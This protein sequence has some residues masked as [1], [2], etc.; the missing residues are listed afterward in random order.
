H[1]QRL[2][3][4]PI[5]VVDQFP[6]RLKA[7]RGRDGLDELD[8]LPGVAELVVDRM[9]QRMNGCRLPPASDNQAAAAVSD[10]IFGDRLRPTLMFGRGL[11]AVDID[12]ADFYGDG[13]SQLLNLAA[14]YRKPMVRLCARATDGGFSDIEPIHCRRGSRL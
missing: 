2:N 10:Q 8:C 1:D 12:R 4:A 14:W 3:F 6:Q 9:N 13:T 7:R 11:F 5:D